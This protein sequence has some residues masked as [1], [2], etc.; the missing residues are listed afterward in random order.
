MRRYFCGMERLALRVL[1]SGVLGG[2]S[3][4]RVGETV[5]ERVGVLV[6]GDT[7]G[8]TD[9]PIWLAVGS[10]SELDGGSFTGAFWPLSFRALRSTPTSTRGLNGAAELGAVLDACLLLP[11]PGFRSAAGLWLFVTLLLDHASLP[12][13]GSEPELAVAARLSPNT[14]RCQNRFCLAI[15]NMHSCPISKYRSQCRR[16]CAKAAANSGSVSKS[17]RCGNDAP[18]AFRDSQLSCCSAG[19][20]PWRIKYEYTWPSQH[21][22]TTSSGAPVRSL[23][24]VVGM[25]SCSRNC[26]SPSRFFWLRTRSALRCSRVIATV[27][28]LLALFCLL[29]T[30]AGLVQLL[31]AFFRAWHS[32]S[33]SSSSGGLKMQR[34]TPLQPQSS[35]RSARVHGLSKDGAACAAVCRSFSAAPSSAAVWTSRAVNLDAMRRPSAAC[36]S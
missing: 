23:R 2:I 33:S 16:T 9:G 10:D 32:C 1:V 34:P 19:G 18:G 24:S 3:A 21:M 29:L 17:L 27:G 26:G 31:F 14:F 4:E 20:G 25:P 8:D 6:L 15:A 11:D 7:D 12:A 22:R 13:C 35:F 36:V 28:V 30:P 5:G